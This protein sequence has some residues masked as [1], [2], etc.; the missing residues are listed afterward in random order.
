MFH[1]PR[2]IKTSG[3]FIYPSPKFYH[4]LPKKNKKKNSSCTFLIPKKKKKL[5]SSCSWLLSWPCTAVPVC[6]LSSGPSPASS[7]AVLSSQPINKHQPKR[8][9]PASPL[10]VSCLPIRL[11]TTLAIQL[12]TRKQFNSTSKAA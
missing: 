4:L 12:A 9:H 11:F 7:Q 2:N 1:L 10:A 6:A 5:K 8:P 3:Q